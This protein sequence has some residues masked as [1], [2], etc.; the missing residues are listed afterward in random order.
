MS[1][2]DCLSAVVLPPPVTT[3]TGGREW[4]LDW[5]GL[6]REM[7]MPWTASV[8]VISG[9][10]KGRATRTPMWSYEVILKAQSSLGNPKIAG[11]LKREWP[12]SPQCCHCPEDPIPWLRAGG[13]PS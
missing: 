13:K 2:Q 8:L 3:A 6:L 4:P 5:G 7:R 12:C 1:L 11:I 9:N 10:R